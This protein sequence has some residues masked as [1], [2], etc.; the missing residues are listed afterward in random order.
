MLWLDADVWKVPPDIFQTLR[1]SGGRI[2]VPDCT[3]VPGGPS[4]DKNTFVQVTPPT[5]ENLYAR[6][7]NG[8]FQP[9]GRGRSRLYLDCVR[10]SDRIELTSVGGTV[11]LVDAAL[12]RAGLRFP[13]IPYRMHIETEGFALLARDLGIIP[14]TEAAK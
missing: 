13:E 3:R 6:T 5:R 8:V 1:A 11:L 12:H 2:V 9:E 14:I 10:H 4:F 7:F